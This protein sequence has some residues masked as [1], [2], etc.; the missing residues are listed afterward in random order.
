MLPPMDTRSVTL[1]CTLGLVAF[2]GGCAS[3]GPQC[4]VG[5][6]LSAFPFVATADS[7]QKSPGNQQRFQSSVRNVVLQQGSGFCPVSALAAE[8]Y[9]V[10]ANPEPDRITISSANDAT[11]GTATCT[12]P[13]SGEVTLTATLPTGSSA[14]GSPTAA[15]LTTT[16]QLTCK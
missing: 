8:V 2:A 4:R 7:T 3:A 12:G 1:V 10:W 15:P 5:P 16:V 6:E 9:P 11:N 13:T 14:F